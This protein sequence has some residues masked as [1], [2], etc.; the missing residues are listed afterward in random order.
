[1]KPW[2]PRAVM[3]LV[4][5][6]IVDYFTIVS[7]RYTRHAD[8]QASCPEERPRHFLPALASCLSTV[9]RSS[10]IGR[11]SID[12]EDTNRLSIPSRDM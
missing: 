4:R 6:P 1:M 9:S 7:A 11:H 12:A 5:C 2:A 8:I 3:A 10:A